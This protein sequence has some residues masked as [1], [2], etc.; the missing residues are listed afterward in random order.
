MRIIQKY[1]IERLHYMQVKDEG[2][3]LASK[4]ETKV[5]IQKNSF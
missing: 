1:T 5:D 4:V 3:N 2:K